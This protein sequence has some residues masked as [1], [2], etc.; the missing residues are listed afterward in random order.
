[1]IEMTKTH[2]MDLRVRYQ[3]TDQ[4]GIVYYSNYLVWFEIA[5]TELFR[6][7]G[8]EYSSLEKEHGIF[9][10][11]TEAYCKYKSPLRYDETVTVRTTV[12]ESSRTRLG[13]SY[14]VF[15]GAELKATGR[16]RHAFVD[17]KGKP[18]PV[19]RAIARVFS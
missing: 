1:V 14:E 15:S 5:R 13:F 8:I 3:E 19:P 11:V 9:L 6:A 17:K 12:T 2:S 7:R 4:M 16:T 18:V 10:P